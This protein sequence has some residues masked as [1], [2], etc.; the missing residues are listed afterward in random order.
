MFPVALFAFMGL[1]LG[2]WISFTSA[3]TIESM[4][5]FRFLSTISGFAF[6]YLPVLFAMDI[7]LGLAR[8]HKGVAAFLG[9]V[10][11]IIMNL[12]INFYLTLKL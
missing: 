5:F 10:G 6:T 9:L 8:H 7:P 1:I 3:T 2:I 4:P 12:S 11:Y